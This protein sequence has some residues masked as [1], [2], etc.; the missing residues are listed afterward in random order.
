MIYNCDRHGGNILVS[1]SING[2]VKLI[3]I[4]QGFSLVDHPA[5]DIWFEWLNWKQ[6]RQ[7][8]SDE[9]RNFVDSIDVNQNAA[10]LRQLQIKGECIRVAKASTTLLKMGVAAGLSMYDIGQMVIGRRTK[11]TMEPSDFER[12]YKHLQE[13]CGSNELLFMSSLEEQLDVELIKRLDSTAAVPL[14][15]STQKDST[16]KSSN[17]TVGLSSS[18]ALTIKRSSSKFL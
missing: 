1:K 10:L 11:K 14:Q 18:P 13:S 2:Q 15:Q 7:P 6:S 8:L 3:P 9:L 17:G 16:F 5:S 12:I 4:D